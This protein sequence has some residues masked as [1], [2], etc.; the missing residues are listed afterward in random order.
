VQGWASLM[1]VLLVVGGLQIAFLGLIG[2][3]VGRI[4]MNSN[5]APNYVVRSLQR[6]KSNHDE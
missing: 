4:L 2:E 3:Y 5:Q 1:V 6:G